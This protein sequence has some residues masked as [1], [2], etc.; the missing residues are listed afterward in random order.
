MS[1]N[2]IFDVAVNILC[3]IIACVVAVKINARYKLGEN[4]SVF[5]GLTLWCFLNYLAGTFLHVRNYVPPIGGGADW[6]KAYKF[7]PGVFLFAILG[8]IFW[9]K[10]KRARQGKVE[11]TDHDKKADR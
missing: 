9:F 8:L 6:Q 10:E 5:A 7:L 2:F 1:N 11:K 3:L 4:T